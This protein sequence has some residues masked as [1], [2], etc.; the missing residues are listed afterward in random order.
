MTEPENR[1]LSDKFMLRLPDGMRERIKKAAESNNRSMNAELLATLE[2]K[3]PARDAFDQLTEVLVILNAMI[4]KRLEPQGG[5]NSRDIARFQALSDSIVADLRTRFPKRAA[6][7]KVV[8]A[9]QVLAND[10]IIKGQED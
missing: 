2:E 10:R 9:A 7:D 6:T 1:T 8:A 5:F 4:E 3:Y